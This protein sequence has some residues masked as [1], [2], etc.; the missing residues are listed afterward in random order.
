MDKIENIRRIVREMSLEDKVALC[1]GENFWETKAY[2]KYGIPSMF[3][4]DGPHG[5]RR[6]DVGKGTDMLGVNESYPST[7]FPSEVTTGGSWD[8]ELMKEIGIAI[9]EEAKSNQVGLV[10]GPGVNIKRNPL[11]G[12]NFEYF[13][14]DPVLA[15]KLAGAF[16]E[17]IESMGIGSSLKHFA[18]NSQETDRFTSD[19]IIDE[20]TLRELYLKAFEIAV[21]A[22]PATVMCAYPKLNGIHCSDNKDLLT[23]ILRDEWGYEGLVITDWGAMNDRIDGFKAGCDLSMPGGSDYMEAD[24]C[25]AVREGRIAEELIDRSS[26]RILKMI[27][28]AQETIADKYETDMEQHHRLAVKAAEKGGVLLKNEDGILPLSGAENILIAGYM[29]RDMRIQG[30]GSSHINPTKKEDPLDFFKTSKYVQG[31]GKDGSSDDALLSEVRREAALADKVVI[32]AGL[33][34]SMESEGF[35]RE[36]M[37]MPEGQIR[38]IETAAEA[39]PD[40]IVVLLCGSAV[41]CPWAEKVKAILYM[42]LPGQGG[43]EAVYDLL[44]GRANPCGKLTESWPYLYKDVPSSE[45]FGKT[46]DALYQEGLYVGYR[47][48]EKTGIPV[49]W[50][51]GYGLSYT[52][53]EYS[54]LKVDN[55]TVRVRITN[56]GD[57]SGEEVVQLYIGRDGQHGIHRP[58]REMKAF[59]KVCLE[60]GESETVTFELTDDDFAVWS[61]GWKIEGGDYL[62][63]VSDQC[64]SVHKD[65]ESFIASEQESWYWS[66]SGKPSPDDWEKTLGREYIAPVLK[67]GSFTMD[68][69]VEEMKDYSLIMRIMYKATEGVIAK[70]FGGKKDYSNPEFRMLIKASAGGPLRG[71]QISGGIK[72]GIFEGLLEM[73]NGHFFRGIVRMIKG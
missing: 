65:S 31:C 2:E 59:L 4:C 45:I 22:H 13:S 14:E 25:K 36:S 69:T 19:S 29:A 73:A 54:D 18:C 64:C 11:C 34:A 57:I 38:M 68:N 1:S 21:K 6:Q 39:N 8:T 46:R 72:G 50:P 9:G 32:F 71:M 60:P 56:T 27:F 49:R 53:F 5:L 30:A 26:E 23:G 20:R 3:M 40:T 70:Q 12:R 62:I 52:S 58:L 63:S 28:R 42:G 51:F 67:K 35:D 55:N 66:T 37:A 61:D 24:V 44:T 17:G 7:C 10:L 47:Y 15:G 43:A 48:Y 16:I 41:E 33:P